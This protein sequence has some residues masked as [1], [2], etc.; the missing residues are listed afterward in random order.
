MIV[1]AFLRG[2]NLPEIYEL[3][4]NVFQMIWFHIFD[5]SVTL[6]EFFSTK[7]YFLR[8]LIPT[9]EVLENTSIF[10]PF[11]KNTDNMIAFSKINDLNNKTY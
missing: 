5:F 10:Q 7:S 1:A 6:I 4:K 11:S 3:P 9:N 2:K 8:H